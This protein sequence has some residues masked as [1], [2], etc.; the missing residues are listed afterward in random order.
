MPLPFI[1]GGAAAAIGA[2]LLARKKLKE[3]RDR[4]YYIK[5]S[6]SMYFKGI[7]GK[8]FLF[9]KYKKLLWASRY[10][11]AACFDNEEEARDCI[12]QNKLRNVEIIEKNEE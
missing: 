12:V 7:E 11:D 8:R 1:I 6:R 10:D 2:T 9:I 5:N 3:S 4:F